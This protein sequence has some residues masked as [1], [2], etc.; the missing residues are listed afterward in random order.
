[1]ESLGAQV[2]LLLP[3]DAGPRATKELMEG[4]GGLLL[5]A[6][7]DVDPSLYHEI[8]DPTAGLQIC[9]L[10]DDLE[11]R[12]LSYALNEDIPVLAISRGMQVLN[13]ALGGR[14][15]QDLPG[16]R[17]EP[18][19]G[20]WVSKMHLIYVSPGSKAAAVM[21]MAGFF[22]VNSRHRQGLKEAQRS[23]RLM[24]TAYSVDDGVVEGLESPEHSWVIGVQCHPEIQEEVPRLFA[25]LFNA[26]H[27]R[28]ESYS[29]P[30]NT[31]PNPVQGEQDPAS[32]A[33]VSPEK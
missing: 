31:D 23:P 15:I 10:L 28:A 30:P 4:V 9:P 19:D 33:P 6:G 7:P 2:R 24:T 13:V 21:G 5:P 8:P 18:E 25:N 17:A 1:M 26:F 3:K 22:R 16:H 12:L 14:L 11:F 32:G 20:D 27:Q 29:A